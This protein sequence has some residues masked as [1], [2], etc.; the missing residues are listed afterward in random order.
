MGKFI[1]RYLKDDGF[2]RYL[3]DVRLLSLISE[4]FLCKN[5]EFKPF[6]LLSSL[7]VTDTQ[8]IF[9]GNSHPFFESHTSLIRCSD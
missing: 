4:L 7:C 2:T 6:L 8:D 9:R 5:F 3:A 1:N